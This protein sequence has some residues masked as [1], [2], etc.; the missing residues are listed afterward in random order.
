MYAETAGMERSCLSGFPLRGSSRE[1]GDEV[2]RYVKV[3]VKKKAA[4]TVLMSK[5]FLQGR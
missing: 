1:A 3:S 5:H 2:V 4:P